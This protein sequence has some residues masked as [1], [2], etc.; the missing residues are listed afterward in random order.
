M[1]VRRR[2][3]NSIHGERPPSD[4]TRSHFA[5]R[6]GV[7]SGDLVPARYRGSSAGWSAVSQEI[8]SVP[9]LIRAK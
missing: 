1:K 5:K 4:A 7:P 9:E 6:L 3:T 8:G 2:A